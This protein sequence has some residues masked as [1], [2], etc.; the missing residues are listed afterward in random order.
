VDD[1]II[2]PIKIDQLLEKIGLLLSIEWIYTHTQKIEEVKKPAEKIHES[3][4]IKII[5]ELIELAEVGHLSELKRKVRI[6]N[7]Q[8]YIDEDF[9]SKVQTWLQ[10]VRFDKL[11]TYLRNYPNE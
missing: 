9:A 6:L 8:K 2:K 3:I 7:E 5:R 10:E 4:D 11:I 1:H